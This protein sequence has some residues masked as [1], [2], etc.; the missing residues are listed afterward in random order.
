MAKTS[1]FYTLWDFLDYWIFSNAWVPILFIIFL[2]VTFEIIL[3][4]TCE[5]LKKKLE[6]WESGSSGSQK[7]RNN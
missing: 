3:V 5:F 4:K 6:L 1:N 7:V 2:G